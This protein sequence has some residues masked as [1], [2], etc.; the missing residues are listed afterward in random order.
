VHEKAGCSVLDNLELAH[1]LGVQEKDAAV[2]AH[3]HIQVG[4]QSANM[5]L[6][7]GFRQCVSTYAQLEKYQNRAAAGDLLLVNYNT[8]Q[9]VWAAMPQAC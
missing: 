8:A 9:E 3:M 5:S 1:H 2:P 7:P 6:A 4:I